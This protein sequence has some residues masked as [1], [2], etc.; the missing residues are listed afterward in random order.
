M[1]RRAGIFDNEEF[2]K[3]RELV[4]RRFFIVV[5]DDIIPPTSIEP[6]F[7]SEVLTFSQR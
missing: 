5:A 6:L 3:D 4:D 2:S 7:S 1:D